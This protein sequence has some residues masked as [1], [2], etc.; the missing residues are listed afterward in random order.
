MLDRQDSLIQNV[1]NEVKL[2]FNPASDD[3]Y[4]F[5]IDDFVLN[6]YTPITPQL[7]FELAE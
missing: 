2:E 1:R 3:F 7:T 6:D 5:T 4:S